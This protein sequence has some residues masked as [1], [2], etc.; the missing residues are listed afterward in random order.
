M[1]RRRLIAALSATLV[2]RSVSPSLAQGAWP[3]QVVRIIVPFPAGGSADLQARLIAEHLRG[4]L[5]Q[6]V[7][8]ENKT[9]SGGNIAAAEAARAEADGHTLLYG[10]SGTQ[11]INQ[12]IYRSLPYDPEKDFAPIT[13]VTDAPNLLVVR[14]SLPASDLSEFL[15]YVRANPGRLNFGSSGVGSTTHVAGEMF[16]ALTGTQMTHVPY[17]GQGPALADLVAGRLDA[18][19]PLIPDVAGQLGTGNVRVLAI[20]SGNRSRLI[21]DIPTFAEGGVPDLASSAWTGLLAPAGTP[22][23]VLDR[24][25]GEIVR[26][27]GAGDFRSR[28][29]ELGIEVRTTSPAGFAEFIALERARWAKVIGDLGIKLD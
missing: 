18:M 25:N 9:G 2:A 16:K 12:S 17:R 11:A 4:A 26:L 29:A 5:G 10:T 1:D 23:A 3:R 20:A 27:A 22:T 15:A 24:L 19:F 7:I 6:S 28:L 13:L 21:P 14:S 8:V